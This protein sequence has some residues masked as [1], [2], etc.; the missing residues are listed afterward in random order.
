LLSSDEKVRMM[1]AYLL[2]YEV[3]DGLRKTIQQRMSSIYGP[4]WFD[5]APT[6]QRM[7]PLKTAFQN[8]TFSQ[9]ETYYLRVYPVFSHSLLFFTHLNILY[10]LRNK[11]AHHHCLTTYEFQMIKRSSRF[12]LRELHI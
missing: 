1:Q 12:V 4:H 9:Y 11:V 5:N 8:L 6:S 10:P 7:K 2:L 3:E